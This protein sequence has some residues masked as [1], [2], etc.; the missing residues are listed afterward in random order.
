VVA[1]PLRTE[2]ELLPLPLWRARRER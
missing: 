2:M 1:G